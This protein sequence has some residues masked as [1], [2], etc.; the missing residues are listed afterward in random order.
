MTTQPIPPASPSL[1]YQ[2]LIDE[3][4]W[5]HRGE[6]RILLY[7]PAGNQLAL[8]TDEPDDP[9]GL[10]TIMFERAGSEGVETVS[11]PLAWYSEHIVSLI[12][13]MD[14]GEVRFDRKEAEL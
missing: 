9:L 2:T 7:S 6:G 12:L 3:H 11:G 8:V 4:G 13:R 5:A 14:S 10:M 1:I